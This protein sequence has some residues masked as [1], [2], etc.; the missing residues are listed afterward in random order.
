MLLVNWEVFNTS[1]KSGKFAEEIKDYELK[2]NFLKKKYGQLGFVRFLNTQMADD[3]KGLPIPP[4]TLPLVARDNL[5]EWAYTENTGN[6]RTTKDG[7]RTLTRKSKIMKQGE[8]IVDVNKDTDLLYFI[9]EKSPLFKKGNIKID[10]IREQQE[11]KVQKEKNA[12]RLKA[13]IYGEASPLTSE[14]MLRQV[15]LALGISGADKA[16]EA[17]LRIKLESFIWAENK[18][19]DVRGMTTENFLDFIAMNDEV[20][21]RGIIGKAVA[22]K[23]MEYTK[24]H[25]WIW[26]VSRTTVVRVPDTRYSDKFPYLCEFF[27]NEANRETWD[28]LVKELVEQGYF[29]DEQPYEELKW[30]AKLYGIKVSQTS[31]TDLAGKIKENFKA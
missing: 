10:D 20:M 12:I 26:G 4:C 30:L 15:C 14:P 22:R 9:V 3:L 24:Q 17:S 19:K 8:L 18:R 23:I 27:A 11:E 5:T 6:I 1:D 7:H 28:A 25:G 13:A 21:R 29:E 2:T 31:K 16:T